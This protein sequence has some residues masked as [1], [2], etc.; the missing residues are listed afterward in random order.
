[1]VPFFTGGWYQYRSR[2]KPRIIIKTSDST[3]QN[4][5]G[6]QYFK[7]NSSYY[8][9]SSISKRGN[10]ISITKQTTHTIPTSNQIGYFPPNLQITDSINLRDLQGKFVY[11]YFWNY[12]CSPCLKYLPKKYAK[13]SSSEF[14]HVEFVLISVDK[15]EQTRK[16]LKDNSITWVNIETFGNSQLYNDYDISMFPTEFLIDPRGILIASGV[17]L[18]ID[19]YIDQ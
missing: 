9:I 15:P 13:Y 19:E 5:I 11:L 17:Y 14:D 8:K 6:Y 10:L 7:I 2:L 1:V 18:N 3:D 12:D 16:F 4:I